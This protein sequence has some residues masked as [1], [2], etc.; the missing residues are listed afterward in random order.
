MG[1][2]AMAAALESGAIQGY[3][4]AAPFWAIPVT[5]GTG[6]LWI[7]GPRGELPEAST[8]A[9]AGNMQVM[10]DF[11]EANPDLVQRLAAVFDELAAFVEKYPVEARAQLAKLYPDIDGPTLD[12]LFASESAGWRTKHLTPKDM[13]KEIEF[14]KLGGAQIPGLEK[15]DPRAML[16]P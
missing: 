8:P 2:P 13:V 15:V 12:L 10:R 1:Q 14:V 16:Y 5:K 11:A 6:V 4:A 9:S 7:S 3:S